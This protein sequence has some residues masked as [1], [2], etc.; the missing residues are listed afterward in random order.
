MSMDSAMVVPKRAE[1]WAVVYSCGSVLVI[2]ENEQDAL[3]EASRF[4]GAAV[5]LVQN[6]LPMSDSEESAA[7]L[8]ILAAPAGA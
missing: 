4:G 2:F 1:Q 3:C 6:A 8:L 7:S 5:R